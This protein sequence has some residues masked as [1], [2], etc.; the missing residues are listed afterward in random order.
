MNIREEVAVMASEYE[1]N[2]SQIMIY[3]R[4]MLERIKEKYSNVFCDKEDILECLESIVSRC[5]SLQAKFNKNGKKMTTEMIINDAVDSRF[6][7][8]Y[9]YFESLQNRM[10]AKDI[11]KLD[12]ENAAIEAEF[13]D[14]R[15]TL[16]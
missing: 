4:R 5:S 2:E 14:K 6:D 12:S 1:V 3:A 8:D 9:D 10:T 16:G 15:I 13:K 7:S 11:E